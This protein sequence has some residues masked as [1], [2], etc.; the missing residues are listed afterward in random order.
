MLRE[1][2]TE[3][4]IPLMKPANVKAFLHIHFSPI[5]PSGLKRLWYGGPTGRVISSR[6]VYYTAGP[7]EAA[8]IV[9][10]W[11]GLTFPIS[12]KVGCKRWSVL[13]CA[14]CAGVIPVSRGATG[15]HYIYIRHWRRH[16]Q[17]HISTRLSI[18]AWLR[19][20][21]G[22]TVQEDEKYIKGDETTWRRKKG[23]RRHVSE[24]PR[25]AWVCLRLRYYYLWQY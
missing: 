4:L 18:K 19:R 5:M 16:F 22:K 7:L 3:D 21:R 1:M 10:G 12:V 9:R 8:L 17:M 2:S 15:T 14:A 23:V 13:K 6:E 11:R 20:R 25:A 24:P